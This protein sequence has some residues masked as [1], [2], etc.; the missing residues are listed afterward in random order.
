MKYAVIDISGHQS[1]VSENETITIDKVDS[2]IESKLKTDKVLLVVNDDDVQ[3]GTPQVKGASV[4]YQIVKH[5]KGQK[6]RVFKYKAKS[7][8][9]KTR[10]FR[11]QLTDIKITKI[12]VKKTK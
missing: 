5:Y 2:P 12:Q 6:I 3:V 4:N 11:A 1:I 10:G 9:R 7:R 8:Y